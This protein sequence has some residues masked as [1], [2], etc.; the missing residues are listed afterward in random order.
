[1]KNVTQFCC[2]FRNLEREISVVTFRN[3]NYKIN[4]N[5]NFNL[6]IPINVNLQI[7]INSN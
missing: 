5:I 3:I 2:N 7:T 4:C 6:I 1:M